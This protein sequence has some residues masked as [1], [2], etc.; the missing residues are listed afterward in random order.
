MLGVGASDARLKTD[1][2]SLTD[3]IDVF[4]T[5]SRLR[6]VA[7]N[8]D[9]SKEPMKNAPDRREIGMIAQEVE[10]VLPSLVTQNRDGYR[11]LDYAKLAAFLVEV[12]KAQ[13]AEI[14]ELRRMVEALAAQR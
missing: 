8:W 6:G 9:R 2:V 4:E 1:V 12:A 10:D 5:L 13:Q 14:A 7:F 11:S 3:E